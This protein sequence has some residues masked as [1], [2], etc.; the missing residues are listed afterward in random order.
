MGHVTSA[1]FFLVLILCPLVA[2]AEDDSYLNVE[3]KIIEIADVNRQAEAWGTCAAAYDVLAMFFEDQP[4][5]AQQFR[6]FGNGAE[7]AVIMTH[8]SD[9]L[10]QDMGQQEFS[11]L[12]NYSKTLGESI[13]ETRKTTM[14]ADAESAGKEGMDEFLQR[15][16]NTVKQC[17]SNLDGQQAYIDTWRELAKSG[18]LSIPGD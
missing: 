10:D 4:A 12:W 2:V 9:G 17:V 7:L 13:P 14:L 8:I 11:S 6:N 15:V 18:L 3:G 1:V 16:G 5:R